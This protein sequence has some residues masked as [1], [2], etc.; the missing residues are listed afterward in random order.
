[1]VGST[2][3]EKLKR[4]PTI[5]ASC[6]HEDTW[7]FKAHA[8]FGACDNIISAFTLLANLQDKDNL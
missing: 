6:R 7:D 5:Q 3:G 8:P 4:V 1:M 2:T